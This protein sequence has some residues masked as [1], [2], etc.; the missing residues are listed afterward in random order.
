MTG[1]RWRED[2]GFQGKCDYCLEWWP[3]DGEFWQLSKHAFRMCVA[4]IRDYKRLKQAER[5]QDP[6]ARARDRE[7]VRAQKAA[8]NA[9]GILGEYRARWYRANADRIRANKRAT[10]AAQRKADGKPYTPREARP[11][12]VLAALRRR[13]A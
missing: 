8:L 9:A 3:L 11:S 5:R 2:V 13:A 12:G 1:V 4:C 10:Y 7:D 6:D